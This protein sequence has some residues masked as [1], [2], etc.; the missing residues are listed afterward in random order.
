MCEA[1]RYFYITGYWYA[2]PMMH[3]QI[4]SYMT[5]GQASFEVSFLVSISDFLLISYGSIVILKQEF[6]ESEIMILC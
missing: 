1:Q 3:D 5:N 6:P 4:E 2:E